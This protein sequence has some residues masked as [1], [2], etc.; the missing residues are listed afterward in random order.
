[1]APCLINC[2]IMQSCIVIICCGIN[3]I[4]WQFTIFVIWCYFDWIVWG[5]GV[6]V[7]GKQQ[8]AVAVEQREAAKVNSWRVA[9]AVTLPNFRSI[10]TRNLV[11]PVVST[12]KS[13]I[14]RWFR[15]C[16]R[17]FFKLISKQTSKIEKKKKWPTGHVNFPIKFNRFSFLKYEIHNFAGDLFV[18]FMRHAVT[19]D[20]WPPSWPS[21][22]P[23]TSPNFIC[24][25]AVK[26]QRCRVLN[27]AAHSHLHIITVGMMRKKWKNCDFWYFII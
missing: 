1:M 11:G 26:E 4:C 7:E 20:L 13:N 14:H 27:D 15:F 12:N 8:L 17:V 5:V 19:C 23:H 21:R 2:V 9:T 18:I 25:T 16:S 24:F 22:R 3:R 10:L 6:G